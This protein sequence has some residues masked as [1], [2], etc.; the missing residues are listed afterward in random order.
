MIFIYH[1][2]KNGKTIVV[3]GDIIL[4]HYI[5]NNKSHFYLG[6]AANV[7]VNIANTKTNVYLIGLLGNDRRGHLI[8][9]KLIK[10][11]INTSLVIQERIYKT[12]YKKRNIT[13]SGEISL[14]SSIDNA[15]KISFDHWN[16]I[17][18]E[19]IKIMDRVDLFVVSDYQK[20]MIDK[21]IWKKL[22]ELAD[23]HNKRVIVDSKSELSIFKNAYLIKPNLNELQNYCAR[24]IIS[25]VDI[26]EASHKLMEVTKSKVIL[27]TCGK[28]GM[29]WFNKTGKSLFKKA[30][31]KKCINDLGAGD[32]VLSYVAFGLVHF[33]SEENI[34]KLANLAAAEQVNSLFTKRISFEKVMEKYFYMNK[35]IID[36]NNLCLLRNHLKNKTIVFTN[37]CFDLLHVGHVRLLKY[38]AQLGNIL[39][40]GVNSDLSVAKIKGNAR[41]IIKLKERI[42]LL[43]SLECVDYI[44]CFDEIKPIELIKVLKPDILVKGL[45]YLDRDF[46]GKKEVEELGGKVF[47]CPF[48][49]NVSTTDIIKK[50]N[51]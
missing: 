32:T 12:N 23:R 5:K 45:D 21:N 19:V 34:I 42:E 9:K 29:H 4:D 20:G 3:I 25:E 17:I 14:L 50:I 49:A 13:K 11:K 47:L 40:V 7:A 43:S 46:S 44:V 37:G 39:V 24:Q 26:Y 48:A 27:T 6:G 38:A 36:K 31:T 1:E 10:Q 22:I 18:E 15:V 2:F 41:P 35:K 30:D 8:L 28:S 51:S 16:F 33:F